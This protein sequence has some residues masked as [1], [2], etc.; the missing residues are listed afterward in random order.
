MFFIFKA[1]VSYM[2]V[3]SVDATHNNPV[4]N[5]FIYLL[6]LEVQAKAQYTI[7]QELEHSPGKDNF[8]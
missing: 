6:S 2:S 4:L 5:V 7:K 3:L 1:Y 8:N